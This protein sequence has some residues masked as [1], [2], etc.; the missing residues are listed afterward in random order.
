MILRFDQLAQHRGQV[1]MV[2]GCF[3]PL[4]RGHV[5][6][7]RV[8]RG[9]GLPLLCNVTGDDYLSQKHVPFLL[10][11]ERAEVIDAIRYI[12]FTHVSSVSTAE[13]LRELRP[14]YYVKGDDW[15]GRIPSEQA[16]IAREHQIEIVYLSTVHDSSTR[17]LQRFLAAMEQTQP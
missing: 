13:V 15:L 17:I 7:F 9:L 5:E 14:R 6:Y 3:D 11:A 1:A 10:A 8:A 12:D 4:H 2:D 16:E